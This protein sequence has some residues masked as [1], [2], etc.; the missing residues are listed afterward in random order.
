M[1]LERIILLDIIESSAP[2]DFA[3]M[4]KEIDFPIKDIP[5][6]V[7]KAEAHLINSI[8]VSEK[9][10]AKSNLA[11]AYMLLGLLHKAENRTAEASKNISKA[12]RIFEQIDAE[13]HIKQAKEA[14]ASL[15]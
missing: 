14:L 2:D 11:E 3:A 12:I 1:F 5:N 9:I 10:G 7:K 15:G 6:A 4:A 13:G 8:E